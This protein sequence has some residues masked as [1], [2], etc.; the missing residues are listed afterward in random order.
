M[1]GLRNLFHTFSTSTKRDAK[2]SS[3]CILLKCLDLK[4]C[5]VFFNLTLIL[6]ELMVRAKNYRTESE[7]KL[8]RY[9]VNCTDQNSRVD[10]DLNCDVWC[11]WPNWFLDILLHISSFLIRFKCASTNVLVYLWRFSSMLIILVLMEIIYTV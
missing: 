6:S 9:K 4:D 10:R 1:K 5:L 11:N 8:V 7:S 3:K 2:Y